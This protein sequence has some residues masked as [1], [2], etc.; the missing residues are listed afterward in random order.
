MARRT[1][2]HARTATPIS[3]STGGV[4]GNARLTSSVAAVLFLLLFIEGVTILQIGGLIS[5]HVF[6][7]VVLIPPLLLKI[8]TTSW[9]FVRYYGGSPAYVRKGPPAPLLR[10]FG[11]LIVVLSLA[12][13]TSG[14]LL[15]VVAPSSWRNQL[16]QIHQA[17]FLLWFVVTAVHVLGH[18]AETLK[19]APLDW[20]RATRRQV[21]GASAR[22]WILVIGLVLGLVL[23]LWLTPY[24]AGWRVLLSN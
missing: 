2:R 8:A 10:L 19:L 1:P 7:G 24:A 4:E 12:V 15:V 16:L 21:G 22:Q 5:T 13:M 23:A 14:L 20:A 3:Q 9:R 17:T 6:V 18:L 11:P